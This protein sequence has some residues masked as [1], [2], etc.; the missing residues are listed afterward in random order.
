LAICA[1]KPDRGSGDGGSALAGQ[2]GFFDGDERLRP[3]SAAGD[4][5]ERLVRVIDFE[6]FSG[7]VES[8]LSRSDRSKGGR[9]PVTRC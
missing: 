2:P 7:D 3:L 9:P 8:A 5:L 4:R 1:R 6:L